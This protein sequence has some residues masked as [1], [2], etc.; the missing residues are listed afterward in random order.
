MSDPVLECR[1]VVKTFYDGSRELHILRGIDL[2]I[3]YG[4]IHVISGQEHAAAHHRH[5]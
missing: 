1:Q 4:K 3:E 5:A 2:D